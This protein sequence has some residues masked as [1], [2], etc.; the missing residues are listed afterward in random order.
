MARIGY[1]PEIQQ[2]KQQLET[3]EKKG[4]IQSWELPYENLLTRLS[5][6]LFF[7][8]PTGDMQHVL[9]AIKTQPTVC[10]EKNDKRSLSDLEYC[11]FFQQVE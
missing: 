2:V 8:T 1:V 10:C 5:A 6:A 11:L 7:V 4:I 9:E 3:L